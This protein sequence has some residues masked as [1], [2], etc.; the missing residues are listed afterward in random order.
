MRARARE[1]TRAYI[2]TLILYYLPPPPY[3]NRSSKTIF[4][5]STQQINSRVMDITML[6]S[7]HLQRLRRNETL[8]KLLFYVQ[9]REIMKNERERY[10]RMMFDS[11]TATQGTHCC[12]QY[13]QLMRHLAKTSSAQGRQAFPGHTSQ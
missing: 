5:L 9:G 6:S 12:K 3:P 11:G 4:F 8:Y 7:S 13:G 10:A 2:P 1:C